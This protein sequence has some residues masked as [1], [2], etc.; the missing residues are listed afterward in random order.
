MQRVLC[1]R[2]TRRERS[3]VAGELPDLAE[4]DAEPVC[5]AF[6]EE[7]TRGDGGTIEERHNDRCEQPGHGER[8]PD[9]CGGEQLTFA[10]SLQ[11]SLGNLERGFV[12]V[13]LRPQL[14]LQRPCFAPVLGLD[15]TG[16]VLRRQLGLEL[17]LGLDGPGL[18]P[19]GGAGF[20]LEKAHP[21]GLPVISST[22]CDKAVALQHYRPSQF[23]RRCA[24]VT[25][26]LC[27]T[28]NSSAGLCN[29]YRA[30]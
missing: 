3:A 25:G 26:R 1:A 16:F 22:M 28:A 2:D 12:A 13:A 6:V 20:A 23:P 14:R 19:A 30:L 15:P 8:S 9:S 24:P 18:G 27:A 7:T 10:R 29:N 11:L 5:P 4:R 17:G 21:G